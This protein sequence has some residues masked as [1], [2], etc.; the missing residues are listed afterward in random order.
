MK[1][2]PKLN[3]KSPYLMGLG[4]FLTSLPFGY[5][6]YKFLRRKYI[7]Y[8]NN[9]FLTRLYEKLKEIKNKEPTLSDEEK[10]LL[11]DIEDIEYIEE[12]EKNEETDDIK[13]FDD[14][15][16]VIQFRNLYYD[17][18][19]ADFIENKKGETFPEKLLKNL[20]YMETFHLREEKYEE[21]G[22][23]YLSAPLSVTKQAEG[24]YTVVNGRH[25]IAKLILTS[26]KEGKSSEEILNMK[27][28]CKLHTN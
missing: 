9:I 3:Y 10:E 13:Y 14:N 24:K 20:M 21:L 1:Y 28:P 2:L 22:K 12:Y 27:I 23:N 6:G 4:V 26:I 25:R 17:E 7:M 15:I 11:K 5:Y 8:K 18:K 19:V 16:D